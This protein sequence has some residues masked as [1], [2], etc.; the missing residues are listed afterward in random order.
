MAKRLGMA[1]QQAVV[2]LADCRWAVRR[3][4]FDRGEQPMV[5]FE[6]TTPALRK[7]CSTVELHR[8]RRIAFAVVGMRIVARAGGGV[9]KRFDVQGRIGLP[10]HRLSRG[11]RRGEIPIVQTVT[12]RDGGAIPTGFRVV[13]CGFRCVRIRG[14]APRSSPTD[15]RGWAVSDAK[16]RPHRREGSSVGRCRCS[17]RYF[18]SGR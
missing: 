18:H 4:V 2:R 3:F 1:G 15:L 6:P 9:K 7:P 17:W 10:F 5:G 8:R 12:V 14:R 11:S 13:R 16:R